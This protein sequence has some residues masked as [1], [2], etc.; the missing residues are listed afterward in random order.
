MNDLLVRMELE[1]WLIGYGRAGSRKRTQRWT[2]GQRTSR[3]ALS[4]VNGSDTLLHAGES[5]PNATPRKCESALIISRNCAIS[6]EGVRSHL[7][8]RH[9]TKFT[10]TP[11]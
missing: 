6:H 7:S 1:Y 8:T 5:F 9:T 3:P 4:S 2:S 11:L 10:M